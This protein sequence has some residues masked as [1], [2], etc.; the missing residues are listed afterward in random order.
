MNPE[1]VER[2]VPVARAARLTIHRILVGSH[3]YGF[4]TED[5]DLDYRGVMLAPLQALV[6]L[7]SF[8]QFQIQDEEHDV[9]IYELRKFCRLALGCNPN[10][11]D[12]LYAKPEHWEVETAQWRKIYEIRHLFLSQKVRKTFSGYAYSQLKKMERHRKWL[13]DPPDHQPLQPEYGGIWQGSNWRFPTRQGEKRYKADLK[14][15]NQ[16][17]HWLEH[18]N[19]KRAAMERESG[20]DRKHAAHLVRLLAVVERILDEGDYDPVLEPEELSLVLEV[21]EGRCTYEKLI[22]WSEQQSQRIKHM[23][24]ALPEEPDFATVQGVVMDVHLE[25]LRGQD[26]DCLDCVGR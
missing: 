21:K 10:I 13:L 15:W 3:L 24:S 23:Y 17:Q 12:L 16:Y 18:R 7:G 20:Y 25:Y 26:R 22:A 5:S 1:Q 14:T 2:L 9:V 19:P 4:A 6:G 8:E 11:L